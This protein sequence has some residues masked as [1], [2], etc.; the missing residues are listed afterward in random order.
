MS[1]YLPLKS[2]ILVLLLPNTCKVQN[3]LAIFSLNFITVRKMIFYQGK[4]HLPKSDQIDYFPPIFP[5]DI[6]NKSRVYKLIKSLKNPIHKGNDLVTVVNSLGKIVISYTIMN[7]SAEGP[8]RISTCTFIFH[9]IFYYF[10]NTNSID[11]I[12]KNTR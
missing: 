8:T 1:V 2:E 12:T 6:H 5:G 7:L 4:S 10:A 9:F 11:K 3:I